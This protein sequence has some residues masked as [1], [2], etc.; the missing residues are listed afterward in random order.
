MPLDHAQT[1]MH[2]PVRE[3]CHKSCPQLAL[4]NVSVAEFRLPSEVLGS[5]GDPRRDNGYSG[6]GVCQEFRHRVLL[7]AN[8]TGLRR[9]PLDFLAIEDTTLVFESHATIEGRT[10]SL[11]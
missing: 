11:E 3:D 10:V 1:G 4:F 2:P 7:R 5:S 6:A 9:A 8:S